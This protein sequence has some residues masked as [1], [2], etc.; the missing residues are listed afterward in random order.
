MSSVLLHSCGKTMLFCVNALRSHTRMRAYNNAILVEDC[1]LHGY[2]TVFKSDIA[3]KELV[4][5][6]QK[7]HYKDRV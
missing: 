6:S 2:T 1:T 4:S 3:L 5:P 7:P